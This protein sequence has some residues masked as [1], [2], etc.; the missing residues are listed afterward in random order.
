MYYSDYAVFCQVAEV[1]VAT[2]N[3]FLEIILHIS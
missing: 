2:A 3:F 1:H